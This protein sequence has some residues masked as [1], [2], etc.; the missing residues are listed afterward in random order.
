MF[1]MNHLATT[2]RV[3]YSTDTT[4]VSRVCL[5]MRRRASTLDS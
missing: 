5:T 3:R 4:I 2:L 1:R